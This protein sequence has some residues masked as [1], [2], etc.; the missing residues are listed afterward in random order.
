MG[1]KKAEEEFIIEFIEVYHS[2]P[3]LWDVQSK[4]HSNRDKKGEQYDVLLEKYRG[5]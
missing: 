5:R 4:D 1:D 3:A 2:L